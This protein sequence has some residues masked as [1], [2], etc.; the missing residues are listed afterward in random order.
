[1]QT[2]GLQRTCLEELHNAEVTPCV[3]TRRVEF[4]DFRG[5]PAA[6]IDK[7]YELVSGR[8]YTDAAP[9]HPPHDT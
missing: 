2:Y 4:V 7:V 5:F 1:M 6:I 8:A 3:A 9:S